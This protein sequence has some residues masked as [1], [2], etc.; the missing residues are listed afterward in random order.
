MGIPP[1]ALGT[2]PA[3]DWFDSAMA[4]HFQ[5]AIAKPEVGRD[6]IVKEFDSSRSPPSL[7][8][9]A[10]RGKSDTS[11]FDQGSSATLRIGLLLFLSPRQRRPRTFWH[12]RHCDVIIMSQNEGMTHC[13]VIMSQNEGN[14]QAPAVAAP[15]M[16]HIPLTPQLL[17]GLPGRCH[18]HWP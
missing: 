4:T 16:G 15:P 14:V 5:L 17:Q 3:A 8:P 11:A 18:S 10:A 9:T 7:G 1:A 6:C 13:D 2:P 12:P